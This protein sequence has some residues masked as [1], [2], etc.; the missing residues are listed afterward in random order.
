MQTIRLLEN[1]PKRTYTQKIKEAFISVL[2]E[3]RY[4]K[5]HILQLYCANAPFGGNVVG[6]EAASWRYFNRPPSELTWAETATLAVLPNQPSLVYP[7]ANSEILL[8]KRNFLLQKLYQKKY[9]DE[10]TYELSLAESLPSKPFAALR[11]E[12]SASITSYPPLLTRSKKSS[13]SRSK[14]KT[15]KKS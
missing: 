12:A 11:S 9:F 3:I 7:G 14:M 2:F 8:E 5:K 13:G 1:H 10:K 15:K 6:L 4:T